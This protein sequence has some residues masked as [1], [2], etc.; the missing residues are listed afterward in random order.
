L[1][2]LS[3][4]WQPDFPQ[5][6]QHWPFF[7]GWV[8]VF[9]ST[10][11]IC[12]SMPGQTI[13][14]SVFTARLSEAL[15]LSPMQLSVAYM[16]GTL[17]SAFCINAGGRF[18]DRCGARRAIVYSIFALGLVLLGLSF[19]EHFSQWLSQ[20]PLLNIRPWLPPFLVLIIGFALLR[21]TGQGMV[22]LSSR[23]MLGKW[24]NRRRG[25]VT[26]WSGAVVAFVFSGAPLAL[27]SL[28][29]QFG[30]QGT[31]QLMGGFLIVVL[32]L[33]FWVF[34]RDNPEECGLQMDGNFVG[35]E[36]KENLDSVIY[37]DFTLPEARRTFSFWIFTLMFG[38]NGLV[39]TAYTFHI[40]DIGHELNVST[41]Y[42]LGLFVPAAVVSVISGFLIAW[43]TDLSFVR[44]KYLLCLMALSAMLGYI[45]L[46]NGL[47]P[48]GAWLHILGFG[49]SGGC[50]GSLS[51]IVYPRFFGREHLGAISGLFMTVI[52]IASAVGPFLFSLVEALF[53]AYQIGF[54]LAAFFAALIALASLRANN[55]QRV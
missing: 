36:R 17:I 52:M 53:G 22:T 40:I 31:W 48:A 28:I 10:L 9:F 14:V 12:A 7:Y 11:G 44:I 4:C 13:G 41:D 30:W 27:E 19:V 43:L 49:I 25:T 2:T 24:F 34:A 50:F 32:G 20:V 35:K 55:P 26:A 6:P 15:G 5:R 42:I 37:R 8:I 29:R 18:F 46:A 39:I 45:A 16:L 3:R 38:L 54:V 21:F 1:K 23:A 33:L 47:Y 51:A